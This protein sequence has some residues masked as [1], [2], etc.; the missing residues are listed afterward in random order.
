MRHRFARIYPTYALGIALGALALLIK[1]AEFGRYEW[2]S[3]AA[4][5]LAIQDWWP[6]PRAHIFNSPA[7]SISCE[8]F[9][10]AVFLVVLRHLPR[11]HIVAFAMSAFFVEGALFAAGISAVL[12]F[13]WSVGIAE[14]CDRLVY[15]VPVFRLGEFVIGMA[16]ALWFAGHRQWTGTTC[17]LA[18]SGGVTAIL[19]TIWFLPIT[20]SFE[21]PVRS[22]LFFWVFIP[23]FALIIMAMSQ[24]R[25]LA[26][27]ILSTPGIILLGE[28]SYS[29][30]ILHEPLLDL[31]QRLSVHPAI[32]F[33]ATILLSVS[34]FLW[35]ERPAR[36][37]LR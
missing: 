14:A 37:A 4:N 15:R 19:A 31:A 1:G 21:S 29:L 5:V 11:R 10:Y 28:A 22:L 7:W 13:H 34:C 30:Y 35:Y 16:M 9:F 36:H 27:R 33:G 18:I 6:L 8:F 24:G 23:V 3:L 20:A 17:T 12:H 26:C 25:G 2:A 32:T